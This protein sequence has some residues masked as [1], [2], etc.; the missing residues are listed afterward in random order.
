MKEKGA[1]QLAKIVRKTNIEEYDAFSLLR[2]LSDIYFY[3]EKVLLKYIVIQITLSHPYLFINHHDY[4]T[5]YK[6]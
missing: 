3:G 2:N 1:S 6:L 5:V 4:M